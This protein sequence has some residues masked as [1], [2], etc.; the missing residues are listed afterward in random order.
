MARKKQ[1]AAAAP[2]LVAVTLAVPRSGPAGAFNRGDVIE[3]N[4]FEARR[5]RDAGQIEPLAPEVEAG[6]DAAIEALE[7]E[8][9]PETVPADV[10]ETAAA[11]P[12]EPVET[13][14]G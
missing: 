1:T 8:I 4:P 5:M 13:R 11:V 3:V 9:Q 14:E 7:A 6:I 12:A 10:V 2:G